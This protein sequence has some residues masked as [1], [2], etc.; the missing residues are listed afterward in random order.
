[1]GPI[2]RASQEGATRLCGEGAYGTRS[3][4]Y[5]HGR[6]EP[7]GPRSAKG[8]RLDQ[9][10]SRTGRG[11]PDADEPGTMERMTENTACG[12]VAVLGAPNAGKST[13][14]NALVGQKVT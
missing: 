13:L 5:L 7:S 9:A 10:R 12:F 14:V 2:G 1:M 11:A 4:T 8:R 6:G 3:R